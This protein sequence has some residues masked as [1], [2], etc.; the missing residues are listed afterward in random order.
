VRLSPGQPA[1]V[2]K[3]AI[4]ESNE[5]W[6]ARS[7][8]KVLSYAPETQDLTI[9]DGWAFEWAY[10]TGVFVESGKETRIRGKR[11]MVLQ[12]QPDGAW[13]CARGMWN[14]AE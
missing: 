5:R 7:D 2:G 10:F 11:L 14:T 8:V 12:K 3:Q 6:A 13:K 4:R 9:T 1:E